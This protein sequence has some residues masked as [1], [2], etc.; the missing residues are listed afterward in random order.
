MESCRSFLRRRLLLTKSRNITDELASLIA[1]QFLAKR[2]HVTFSMSDNRNQAFG[3]GNI[4]VF[5]PPIRISEIRRVVLL[6]PGSVACAIRPVTPRAVA[7]EE[8][9]YWSAARFFNG[10][11]LRKRR[12]RSSPMK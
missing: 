9:G 10:S 4:G 7:V 12:T 11:L 2:R 1:R 8:F 5:A 3:P 6:P